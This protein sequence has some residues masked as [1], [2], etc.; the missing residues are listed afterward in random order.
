MAVFVLP[1]SL[2]ET[3]CVPATSDRTVRQ[4]ICLGL[5]CSADTL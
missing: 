5:A 2:I 4:S 3:V 1:R